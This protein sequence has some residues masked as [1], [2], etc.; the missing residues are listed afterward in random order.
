MYFVL[1]LLG[2]TVRELSS[3]DRL[4]LTHS[5]GKGGMGNRNPT[6]MAPKVHIVSMAA[7]RHFTALRVDTTVVFDIAIHH[8]MARTS[9]VTACNGR[10]EGKQIALDHCGLANLSWC[11]AHICP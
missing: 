3:D 2:L 5:I 9:S 10:L 4:L 7:M 11:M 1:A 6:D 8:S